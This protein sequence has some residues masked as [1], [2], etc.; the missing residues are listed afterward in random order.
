MAVIDSV[1]ER[2]RFM[3]HL[4]PAGIK[5]LG[6]ERLS[7]LVVKELPR[8]KRR[9]EELQALYPSAGTRELAQRL[10]DGKKGLAGMISGV[11]GVFGLV[12][13]PA[14]LLV[15]AWLQVGLMVDI[16]ALYKVNL[17]S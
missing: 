7:T 17:K 2:L 10:I 14:D 6:G 9:V 16:A 12:T 1:R 15:M 5:R 13:V 11:S 8:A 4:T 3:R